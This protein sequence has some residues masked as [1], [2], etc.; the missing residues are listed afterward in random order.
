MA[1]PDLYLIRHGETL[2]NR[3]GR[4]QGRLDSP[5][6]DRGRA[7][8]LAL[9][10][11]VA[12]LPAARLSSPLGRAAST[13]RILFGDDV[14][15]DDRLA[16]VDVGGFAGRLLSDLRRDSPAAFAGLPHDWYDRT[17][18]GERLAD[19]AA[20]LSA[21]L[22]GLSGPTVIVTH[23]MVLAMLCALATGRGVAAV[24]PACQVQGVLH[25][26]RGSRHRVVAPD[27]V[28]AGQSPRTTLEHGPAGG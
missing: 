21:L 25:L 8:A 14:A 10:P 24:H 17:P 5:L 12:T 27:E 6:T 1:L 20:R 16:E 13:A 19:L 15:L 11:M 7:Q 9:R 2:W 3:E 22:A 18:G 26:V 28:A 4:L 23:G